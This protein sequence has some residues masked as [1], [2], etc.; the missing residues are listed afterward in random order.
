MRTRSI[1]IFLI[2]FTSSW[3]LYAQEIDIAFRLAEKDLI[4]EGI[5]YDPVSK[6][7]FVSSIHKN[8]IVRIDNDQQVK[9]FIKSGQEG[10]GQVL[11]M[12]AHLGKLWVC[13][14][15]GEGNPKGKSMVHAFDIA[16]GVLSKKS[17]LQ[18]AGETHLFN[19]LVI[20]KNGDVFISDSD[21]GAIYIVNSRSKSPELLIKDDR[22]NY[23]NG[24]TLTPNDE[25]IVNTFKGFFKINTI[26]RE[27]KA[28]PFRNY[29]VIGID[30]LSFYKQSLIGIQNITYPVCINQYNLNA[31]FDNIENANVLVSN[32]P[33]FDI[34]TTGVVVDDWFYFIA[35]SQMSNLDKDKIIDP[36]KLK[37]ILIM[38]IKLN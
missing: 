37:E 4:P 11:G 9:D 35:N 3:N 33:L 26:T 27:I 21:Y 13:S 23:A 20:S 14:N 31:L 12:K 28:L 7:F 1:L 24:I 29:Y 18:S 32:H 25:V 19:D 36:E 2:L 38:K 22:L 30:G 8:K 10:I 17:V 5:A 34:P 6:S 16:S 15:T